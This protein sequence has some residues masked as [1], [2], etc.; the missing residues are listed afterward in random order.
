MTGLTKV[1]T[2]FFPD[3]YPPGAL[4]EC[5]LLHPHMLI[6]ISV[7]ACRPSTS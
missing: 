2:R 1:R 5:G 3:R 7:V 6:E 4:V